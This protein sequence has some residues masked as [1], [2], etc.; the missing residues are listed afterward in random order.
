MK[1][2]PKS[3]GADGKLRSLTSLNQIEYD[4]LLEI[5]AL[6]VEKKLAHYTL[7]GEFRK[8]PSFRERKNSSLYGSARKLDVYERKS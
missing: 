7:K 2:T 3:K 5:F 4:E 8:I 6:L 1:Q